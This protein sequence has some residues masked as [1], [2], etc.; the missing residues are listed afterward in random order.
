MVIAPAHCRAEINMSQEHQ[1][2]IK[3][4]G[5][6]RPSDGIK[7]TRMCERFAA[8]VGFSH[9]LHL[10]RSARQ[11]QNGHEGIPCCFLQ[12]WL[13]YCEECIMNSGSWSAVMPWPLIGIH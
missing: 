2:I 13:V 9:L 6:E 8:R 5:K 10:N 1:S 11:F 12:Q 3:R 4:N 7:T